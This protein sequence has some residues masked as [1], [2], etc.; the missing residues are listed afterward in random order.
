MNR[1]LRFAVLAALVLTVA[2]LPALADSFEVSLDTSA[3]AG[4]TQLFGFAITGTMDNSVSLS[5]FTF[6][7]GSAITGTEDCT[8]GGALSGM[9]CSGNMTSGVSLTDNNSDFEAFFTQQFNVGS[10]LSFDLTTTNNFSGGIPDG[11][12]MYF[13]SADLSTCYSDDPTFSEMLL[14]GIDGTPLT[15]ASF[16]TFGATAQGLPAPV[17]TELATVPEPSNLLLLGAAL[18]MV[19]L[20]W[21]YERQARAASL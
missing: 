3:L 7:G 16:M 11:L 12:F 13:C 14:L 5:G 8:L 19:T 17:V 9:G 20:L 10:S 1:M 21:R 15:P 6:V 18:L 2:A 4:T